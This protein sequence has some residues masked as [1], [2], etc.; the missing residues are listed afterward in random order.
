[1]THPSP[2]SR[3]ALLAVVK[4]GAIKKGLLAV[5]LGSLIGA[6]IEINYGVAIDAVVLAAISVLVILVRGAFMNWLRRR[7][8]ETGVCGK[9]HKENSDAIIKLAKDT[10]DA[11]RSIADKVE[12]RNKEVDA[13]LDGLTD[14]ITEIKTD[15]S[16]IRGIME[17]QH[18]HRS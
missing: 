3:F 13:R 16:Y 17:G 2:M 18:K 8:V 1:M 12:T 5:G 4:S 15:V 11:T 7:F 10:V 9:F 14:D 6:G